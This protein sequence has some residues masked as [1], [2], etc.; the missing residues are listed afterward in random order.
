MHNPEGKTRA[1]VSL[2]AAAPG[3]TGTQPATD[4]LPPFSIRIARL[5]GGASEHLQ[6]DECFWTLG[7]RVR[8]VRSEYVCRRLV[9]VDYLD[10]TKRHDSA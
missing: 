7:G 10:A 4:L 5:V 8:S 9:C 3:L 6:T 2:S 1:R